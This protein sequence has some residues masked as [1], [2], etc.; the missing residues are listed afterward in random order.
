M[1]RESARIADVLASL[2]RDFDRSFAEAAQPAPPSEELLAIR[3]ADHPYALRLP[4]IAALVA[5]TSIT[6]LPGSAAELLGLAAVR[7]T[8]VPVYDLRTLLGYA[9]GAPSRWMVLVAPPASDASARDVRAGVALSFTAFEG[10][11]RVLRA[12]LRPEVDRSSPTP[13]LRGSVRANGAVRPIVH[14]P[15]VLETITERARGSSPR[16]EH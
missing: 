10:Q 1:T 16:K 5:D 3:V 6:P 2:Q 9:P 12:D 7:G 11:L 15:S 14:L 4:A 13:M 8:L